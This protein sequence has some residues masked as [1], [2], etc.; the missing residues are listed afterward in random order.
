MT[1]ISSLA[2]TMFSSAETKRINEKNGRAGG[3]SR[4]RA[5]QNNIILLPS[6][7]ELIHLLRMC[8]LLFDV[9]HHRWEKS[10]QLAFPHTENYV[11]P[12]V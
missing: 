11:L 2:F 7:E 3:K 4:V 1:F 8:I 6:L 9:L 10:N 5:D 12:K